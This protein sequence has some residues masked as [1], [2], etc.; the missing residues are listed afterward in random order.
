METSE[1]VSDCHALKRSAHQEGVLS[2]LLF[3][4]ALISLAKTVEKSVKI[5]MYADDIR[6]RSSGH[7]R[8]E[9]CSRLQRS[10]NTIVRR[11][12]I[13]GLA[14]SSDKLSAMAFSRRRFSQ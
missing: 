3:N 1:G 8:K 10:I 2:A 5:S 13:L 11:L 12:R 7:D 9:I 4:I 6:M 14:L